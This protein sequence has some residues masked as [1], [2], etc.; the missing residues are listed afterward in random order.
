[1]WQV[2]P[3]DKDNTFVDQFLTSDQKAEKRS[4]TEEKK[5]EAGQAADDFAV[6]CFTGGT[7][8]TDPPA[9]S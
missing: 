7:L 1:M 4:K 6:G 5:S 8:P 9:E 2:D 3:K